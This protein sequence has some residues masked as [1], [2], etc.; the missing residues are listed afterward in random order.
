M[1]SGTVIAAATA[2]TADPGVV[3]RRAERE[4]HEHGE[5]A[6]PQRRCA[7]VRLGQRREAADRPGR[8]TAT[9]RNAAM[10]R[11]SG[12]PT[13]PSSR[14]RFC[15]SLRA[16]TCQASPLLT[17]STNRPRCVRSSGGPHPVE[18]GEPTDDHDS[19]QPDAD[20]RAA[21]TTGAARP[22]R[23]AGR[24]PAP[25]RADRRSRC[26]ARARRPPRPPRHRSRR[27]RPGRA[28]G[29]QIAAARRRARWP[30][31]SPRSRTQ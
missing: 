19:G 28:R 30:G 17:S 23:R 26:R 12:P 22:G 3:E 20:R 31:A 11:T 21:T 16:T 25:S 13:L 7:L 10:S 24:M 14:S 6:R 29:G 27:P 9:H 1:S 15:S 2:G 18:Q 5:Q 4:Q 8:R